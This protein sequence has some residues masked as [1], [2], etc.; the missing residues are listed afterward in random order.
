M[1]DDI[2]NKINRLS[3]NTADEKPLLIYS[4]LNSMLIVETYFINELNFT[5]LN[6]CK[7]VQ[8]ED[9]KD[10]YFQSY[11]ISGRLI[12]FYDC[13]SIS[14]SSLPNISNFKLDKTA[15]IIYFSNEPYSKGLNKYQL[16]SKF[17][18]LK[19]NISQNESNIIYSENTIYNKKC[20]R[21]KTIS[22][23]NNNNDVNTN[24]YINNLLIIT[25]KYGEICKSCYDYLVR[26]GYI[27]ESKD[28]Q[29]NNI[30]KGL[31]HIKSIDSNN[32]DELINTSS[33]FQNTIFYNTLN[34][35]Y[36]NYKFQS[37]DQNNNNN[38]N[39]NNI[40]KSLDDVYK[41]IEF[42]SVID[43]LEYNITNNTT[44][45]E[46]IENTKILNLKC[47]IHINN[48][49]YIN[50]STLF[51]F[52]REYTFKYKSKIPEFNVGMGLN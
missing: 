37:I 20:S 32:Y 49:K 42:K 44:C 18:V 23:K 5:K 40:L 11:N 38:N 46:L 16:L 27:I 25:F 47:G 1:N 41:I 14:K 29:N 35:C 45:K 52:K 36:F 51:N 19:L 15:L 24:N 26:A 30:L 48:S 22:N 4:T 12:Y 39:N 28:N 7:V 17:D 9:I 21:C 10:Y 8:K 43:S 6:I 50:Y 33:I 2:K 31:E 13:D 34:T 3:K